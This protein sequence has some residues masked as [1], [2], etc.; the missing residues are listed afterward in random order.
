MRLCESVTQQLAAPNSRDTIPI[1]LPLLRLW[2]GLLARKRAVEAF[3]EARDEA[4]RAEGAAG[5]F[6]GADGVAVVVGERR[7]EEGFPVGIGDVGAEQ[8]GIVPLELSKAGN[9]V[10]AVS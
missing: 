6:A 8:L 7:R 2:P 10:I 4:W 9:L 1:S 3:F 5:A